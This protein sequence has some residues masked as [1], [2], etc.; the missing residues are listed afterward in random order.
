[1]QQF[2]KTKETKEHFARF[3]GKVVRGCCRCAVLNKVENRTTKTSEK[4]RSGNTSYDAT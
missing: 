2:Q 4:E 3:F 1:M